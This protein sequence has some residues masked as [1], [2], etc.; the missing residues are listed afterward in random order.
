MFLRYNFFS[1][2]WMLVIAVLSFLPSSNLPHVHFFHIDKAVHFCLYFFL[3]L[4]TAF[5]WLRQWRFIWLKSLPLHYVMFFC[6]TFGVAIELGQ[7]VF[8][9]DRHFDCSDIAANS[10]GALLAFMFWK[11]KLNKFFTQTML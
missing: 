4:F 5:G 8:T 6:W 9:T 11:V 10:L 2:V 1:I 7:E 3:F